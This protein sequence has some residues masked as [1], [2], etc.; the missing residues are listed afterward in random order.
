VFAPNKACCNL[1]VSLG[2]TCFGCWWESLACAMTHALRLTL[3][4]NK[5]NIS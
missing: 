1:C 4:K 5:A 2:L 3:V